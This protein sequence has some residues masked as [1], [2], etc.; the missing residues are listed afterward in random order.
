MEPEMIYTILGRAATAET[1][2]FKSLEDQWTQLLVCYRKRDW[3]GVAAMI[4]LCRPLFAQFGLGELANLYGER[5]RQFSM[6][7]PPA[8]WDGV[9]VAETK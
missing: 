9:F 5:S 4:N 3:S 6:T 1:E 8:D 7:P 2:E